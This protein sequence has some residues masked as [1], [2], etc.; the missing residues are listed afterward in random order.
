MSAELMSSYTCALIRVTAAIASAV[1]QSR[2][3]EQALASHGT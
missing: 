1:M 3:G 2:G